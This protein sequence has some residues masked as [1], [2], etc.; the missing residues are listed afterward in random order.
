MN[1]I[2]WKNNIDISPE[3]IKSAKKNAKKNNFKISYNVGDAENTK[4]K[5]NQFDA[6]IGR[7]ILHHLNLEQAVKELSRIVKNEGSCILSH[8]ITVQ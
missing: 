5:K 7:G 2:F 1:G 6:V 3:A 8:L 4:F